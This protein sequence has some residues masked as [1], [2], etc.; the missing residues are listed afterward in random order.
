MLNGL[1]SHFLE[2]ILLPPLSRYGNL[3]KLLTLSALVYL[4]GK[5]GK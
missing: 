1:Q 2:L 4:T 3:E 5:W